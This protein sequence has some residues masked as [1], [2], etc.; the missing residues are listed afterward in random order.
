MNLPRQSYK[1]G[2]SELTGIG[3]S[4]Y[5]SWNGFVV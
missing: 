2:L 1:I 5:G 3:P 4:F